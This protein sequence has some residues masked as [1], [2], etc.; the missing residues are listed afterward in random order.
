MDKKKLFIILTG[1]CLT[2][3]LV[4]GL[5]YAVSPEKQ[6]KICAEENLPDYLEIIKPV[7]A[8]FGLSN[9]DQLNHAVLGESIANFVIEPI[10]FTAEKTVIDQIQ[11]HAFYDF[12][13][14]V[15][16]K[17]VM[18]FTVALVDG[19]CPGDIGGRLPKIINEVAVDKNF[20]TEQT[21]ILRL[22]NQ[23][24]V[25]L[26][27]D[28]KW[29]AYSPYQDFAEADLKSRQIISESDLESVLEIICESSLKNITNTDG[30]QI[31][32]STYKI[33]PLKQS[34]ILNG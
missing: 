31:Y 8:D 27:K 23:T 16:D 19:K 25:L 22:A 21:K 24:F 2:M 7:Y 1:V 10:D 32:G 34:S 28:G 4:S 29:F 17:S 3:V 6:A 20:E 30:E 13:V 9:E 12:P 15:D 5:A 14:I 33:A 26:N 11:P 18:D